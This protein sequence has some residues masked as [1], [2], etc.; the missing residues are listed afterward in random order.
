MLGLS[1]ANAPCIKT[2]DESRVLFTPWVWRR[3]PSAL[4]IHVRLIVCVGAEPQ[5]CRVAARRVV[6]IRAIVEDVQAVRDRTMGQFPCNPMR[7]CSPFRP[8]AP[9]SNHERAIAL[10]TLGPKPQPTIAGATLGHLWPKSL[11]NRLG[12][13]ACPHI[14]K[15]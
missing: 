12:R 2:M 3:N 6:A 1:R 7:N 13:N 5:M 11:C 10:G 8:V 15:Q 9:A 4:P 14:R